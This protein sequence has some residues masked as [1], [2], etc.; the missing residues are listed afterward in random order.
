MGRADEIE[1]TWQARVETRT[2]E[3]LCPIPCPN[4]APIAACLEEPAFRAELRSAEAAGEYPQAALAR[5]RALGVGRLFTRGSAVELAALNA[6][7]ARASGSL[8]ITLGVN[9]LALLPFHI[10]ASDELRVAAF[11]R[12]E[13]GDFASLALT[14]L[15]YGSDLL[16]I[17]TRADRDGDGYRVHGEKD[18]INGGT[19]HAILVALARTRARTGSSGLEGRGD[20]SVMWC[21]REGVT[22][23]PRWKTLPGRAADIS[24]LCFDNAPAQRIG[25][26]GDGFGIIQKTLLVSRGGIAALASGATSAATSLARGYANARQLYGGPIARLAPVAEHLRTLR[27][28]DLAVGALSV[29]AALAMSAEGFGAAHLTAVAKYACCRLAEDAVSEG[30]RLF[31]SRAL[32]EELPYAAVASDA[33]LYGVFDGTSHVM[34][35]QIAW[36]LQ[37]LVAARK[38]E[39]SLDAA[40]A[41]YTLTSRSLTESVRAPSRARAQPLEAYLEL[42][43]KDVPEAASLRT[44]AT[45]LLDVAAEGRRTWPKDG[46][47]TI[48]AAE[49]LALLEC[50]IAIV[51]LTSAR[52]ILGMEAGVHEVEPST[53]GL[54][55]RLILARTIAAIRRLGVPLSTE[56]A[57]KS[58]QI[59]DDLLRQ[60]GALRMDQL[61][62]NDP[63]ST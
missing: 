23:L 24:G 40:R 8:A 44:I 14:E 42:L 22:A 25:D 32:V 51:E 13:A 29:K 48:I 59:E 26:E 47:E 7:A 3:A 41:L 6:A 35:G 15:A 61:G 1:R 28:L 27:A 63:D 39:A 52:S 53:S 11:A 60:N 5:L 18:M 16:S 21:S 31:G 50:A 4:V 54:A 34:L 2:W 49:A 57:A 20:L 46:A 12:V 55:M 43:A 10:A 9:S 36:R 33:L 58:A 17:E 56:F 62:S 19:E 45:L 30:R 37:Q 38:G